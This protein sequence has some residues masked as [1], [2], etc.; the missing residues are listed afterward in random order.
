MGT[1]FPPLLRRLD[2]AGLWNIRIWDFGF[3]SLPREYAWLFFWKAVLAHPVKA[4]RGLRRYRRFIREK[5]AVT[6]DLPSSLA[7]PDEEIFWG[8]LQTQSLRP[9]VGLGFRLKPY[10]PDDPSASCPSGRANHECLFLETGE[11]RPVCAGCAIHHLG[12]LCLAAGSPVYVMT[13]AEGIARDFMFPQINRGAF[14][15]AILLL[16][17]Y[18]VRAIVLPLFICGVDTLLLAYATGSC[19]DYGQWLKADRGIKHER[20][21]R[22]GGAEEKFLGLLEKLEAKEWKEGGKRKDRRF[23]RGGN[24]FYPD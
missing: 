22:D 11:M 16:C 13:S 24:I 2:C 15:M 14:P 8:N 3:R 18:S 4:A 10:D 17:P 5:T 21:T 9:L 23:V 19:A 7:I 6:I 20:T 12:R 1:I